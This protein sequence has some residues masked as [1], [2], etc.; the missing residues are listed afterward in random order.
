MAT[1]QVKWF[2]NVKG[3]GFIVPDQ[4]SEDVFVHYSAVKS[5]NGFK[6]LYKGDEVEFEIKEAEKGLEAV[7]VVVVKK[8]SQNYNDSAPLFNVQY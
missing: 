3:Y 1:G 2:D 7:N 4:E 8:A 6:T 5:D